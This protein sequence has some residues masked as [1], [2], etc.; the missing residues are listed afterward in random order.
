VGGLIVLAAIVGGVIYFA[1]S[2]KAESTKLD[3]AKEL[4]TTAPS[5]VEKSDPNKDSTPIATKNVIEQI[6][7]APAPRV[8]DYSIPPASAVYETDWVRVGT[9]ETRVTGVRVG[10]V[11]LRNREGREFTSVA[12]ALRIWIETRAVSGSGVS[13]RRWGGGLDPA[14]LSGPPGTPIRKSSVASGS[15][16]CGELFG[17]HQVL[18]GN[19][20]IRDVLL[21][22][23]PTGSPLL[24]LTLDA[25]HVGLTGSFVH[26]IRA[27]AWKKSDE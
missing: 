3:Q 9:V 7:I 19:P 14:R 11:P 23:V 21:F 15:D 27:S 16:L 6:A 26:V 24:V 10:L 2:K 12:P 5:K 4:R 20:P 25:S 18:P 22:E 1:G 13:L 17:T 8:V